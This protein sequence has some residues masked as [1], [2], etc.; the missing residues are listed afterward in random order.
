[1]QK[2]PAAQSRSAEEPSGQNEPTVHTLMEVALLQK[3][4][5]GQVPRRTL[6]TGQYAPSPSHLFCDFGV[7]Q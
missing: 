5:A 1:M 6:P 2:E 3:L 7:E 4:P